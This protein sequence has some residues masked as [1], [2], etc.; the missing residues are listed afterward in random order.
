MEHFGSLRDRARFS[1]E[2]YQKAQVLAGARSALDVYTLLPGQAQRVHAHPET[3][4]YY[5]VWEGTV[6]VTIG[7]EARQLAPGEAAFAPPGVPHG[8]TNTGT[9]PA[10]IAVFQTPRPA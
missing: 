4:K 7:P 9:E 6:T 5:L 1:P 3:E 8:V 10:I 2:R